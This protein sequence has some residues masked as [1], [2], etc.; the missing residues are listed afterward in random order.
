MYN[1]NICP[2]RKLYGIA[3]DADLRDVA[4]IIISSD[5]VDTDRLGNLGRYVVLRFADTEEDRDDAISLDDANV[6]CNFVKALPDDLD[7]LFVCCDSGE[8][9]SS[10][11]AAAISR[12][13]GFDE[14]EIWEKPQYHPNGLVY[15]TICKGFGIP[16]ISRDI[17]IRK[18]INRNAFKKMVYR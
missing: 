13:L 8:S 3:S 18:E 12:R 1:I 16:L 6:I 10:A 9:R 7:T 15:K 4:A 17:E 11:V 2:V 14:W 5:E